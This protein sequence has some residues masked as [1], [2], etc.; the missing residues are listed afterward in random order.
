MPTIPNTTVRNATPNPISNNSSASRSKKPTLEFQ[1]ASNVPSLTVDM[2][3]QSGPG[4]PTFR[5]PDTP[6]F[7]SSPLHLGDPTELSTADMTLSDRMDKRLGEQVQAS[8]SRHIP[9]K[10]HKNPISKGDLKA[11]VK[12]L[13]A[14]VPQGTFQH[15]ADQKLESLMETLY[16]S[17]SLQEKALTKT[18]LNEA[19]TRELKRF[20]AD[21]SLMSPSDDI[22]TKRGLALSLLSPTIDFGDLN[23]VQSLC[24]EICKKISN[25]KEA[26]LF[27]ETAG[28]KENPQ[29]SPQ[30]E[31]KG[32]EETLKTIDSL[33]DDKG[34]HL[35]DVHRRLLKGVGHQIRAGLRDKLRIVLTEKINEAVQKYSTSGTSEGKNLNIDLGVG[36]SVFGASF[37][38]INFGLSLSTQTAT[39]DDQRI[40]V[41]EN[42]SGKLTLSLGQ[43]EAINGSIA[44][45]VGIGNGKTF[46]K[47]DNYV[48]F[49]VDDILE[50]S[51]NL[52][53]N[54]RFVS[55]KETGKLLYGLGI[56]KQ[57][58][59]AHAPSPKNLAFV[60][61]HAVSKSAEAGIKGLFSCFSASAQAGTKE[62][63]F[64]KEQPLVFA[65]N[66]DQT[67]RSSEER[68]AIHF[69]YQGKPEG[70]QRGKEIAADLDKLQRKPFLQEHETTF[71]QNTQNELKKSINYL[72]AKFDA[73]CG[74]RNKQD[75]RTG[76]ESDVARKVKKSIKQSL[77]ANSTNEALGNI[78]KTYIEL[79]HLYNKTLQVGGLTADH[80]EFQAKLDLFEAKLAK[81]PIKEPF[82]PMQALTAVGKTQGKSASFSFSLGNNL[83]ADVAIAKTIVTNDGNPDNDGN[84]TTIDVS[85]GS[86]ANAFAFFKTLGDG[87]GFNEAVKQALGGDQD[88]APNFDYSK[89]FIQ[90]GKP[91]DFD[92]ASPD[93]TEA[94]ANI[95]LKAT[96]NFIESEGKTKL[97]YV[98]FTA[99]TEKSI[100]V[101][102]IPIPVH[103]GV[104]LLLG[105]N[106]GTSKTYVLGEMMGDDTL[107]Y[108]QTKFNTWIT[109]SNPSW[110]DWNSFMDEHKSSV[111]GMI[112]NLADSSKTI[113]KEAMKVFRDSGMSADTF[114]DTMRAYS[115]KPTH[116]NFD[117]AK[118]ELEGYMRLQ[119][120]LYN[121]EVNRRFGVKAEAL[122]QI[123]P[124]L[125]KSFS[126]RNENSPPSSINP[127]VKPAQPDEVQTPPKTNTSNT[128]TPIG[129]K[130]VT[131]NSCFLNTALKT[132]AADD[133]LVQ[134]FDIGENRLNT[135]V[136]NQGADK[137][138]NYK[139]QDINELAFQLHT[140]LDDIRQGRPVNDGL[141][142]NTL[143]K[144][145]EM[146]MLP[147]G[148]GGLPVYQQQHDAADLVSQKLLP[149]FDPE[150]RHRVVLTEVQRPI[151]AGVLQ[152][153]KKVADYT[154][155]NAAGE[156]VQKPNTD[157]VNL[158]MPPRTMNDKIFLEDLVKNFQK[159]EEVDDFYYAK[160]D[161]V[162]K[163]RAQVSTNLGTP[164]VLNLKLDRTILGENNPKDNREVFAPETMTVNN[165][166]YQLKA[167]ML[168]NGEQ[169]NSGHYKAVTKQ[170]D[171]WYEHNDQTVTKLQ[172][173]IVFNDLIPK[174]AAA[175]TYVRI[176]D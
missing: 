56:T 164:R 166:R 27:P 131:G 45:S 132:L 149:L 57:P 9:E 52:G 67:L 173:D 49:L 46:R 165:Q 53:A 117:K 35:N 62:V 61:T 79:R 59:I 148:G 142:V 111:T 155:L 101:S 19:E 41:T 60:K 128:T 96:F 13:E 161:G 43:P 25:N 70:A 107:T 5:E 94:N 10:A 29:L 136:A 118:T 6:T 86:S 141:L 93:N 17:P 154:P 160:G 99:N 12:D 40:R 30:E 127:N 28:T 139:K 151:D 88:P 153:E 146:E 69:D 98:R 82:T 58:H 83:S 138:T 97:Q 36:I 33:V 116:E 87:K 108:L 72:E 92:I 89:D 39:G 65:L 11:F 76:T 130:N 1:K 95:G 122:E 104:D 20:M 158:T 44:G 175:F 163:G 66:A 126:F 159:S 115:E 71:I 152:K 170:G 174:E 24:N 137:N 144:M 73:L 74:S 4:T 147:A 18:P 77:G 42:K 37:G 123:E 38:K 150:K 100:G 125:R 133:N 31:I 26:N 2:L 135:L 121:R 140:I 50:K 110:D 80:S 47:L 54:D 176:D 64:T 78:N 112:Q 90:F 14:I 32:F 134:L 129:L 167:A 124:S 3:K 16:F 34:N 68:K 63:T 103:P 105:I 15:V 48:D 156:I 114:I 106:A 51:H 7:P 85:F 157:H 75:N 119:N 55:A 81:P 169:Y 113:H 21:L 23:K 91:K 168:H 172:K 143:K 120:S 84:Y 8:P 22:T 102:N 109:E 145:E 171:D 162:Y